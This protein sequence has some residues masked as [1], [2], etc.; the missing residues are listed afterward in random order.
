MSVKILPRIAVVADAAIVCESCAEWNG[1]RNPFRVFSDTYYVGVA[2]L[3]SVLITSKD[4]HVLI[5]G[6][7]SQSAPLIDAHIRAL[8]FRT[9]DVNRE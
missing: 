7:L 8:G 5:D 1:D 4:G 3:S 6:A 9:E 2:G